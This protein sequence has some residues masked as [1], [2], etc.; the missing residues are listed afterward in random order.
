MKKLLHLTIALIPAISFAQN[1]FIN[2]G[3][4]YLQKGALLHVEGSFTNDQGTVKN[5]G[6]IEI[7]GDF[8][9]RVGSVF[10]THTDV[11]S[12]ER[13]VKFT[14][15][16]IQ[17]IK[18]DFT[19]SPFYN[20][21]IDKASATSEVVM[22]TPVSVTGSLIFG[23]NT[24]A[25]TYASNTPQTNHN[26]KG[27]LKTYSGSTEYLLSIKNGASDAIAG[28]AAMSINDNPT[29]AYILTKGNRGSSEGGVE[30]R[31]RKT[32]A[33]DF[34]IGTEENGFNGVRVNFKTIPAGGGFVRGKFNDGTDNMNGFAGVI[35]QQCTGCT[36]GNPS[37]DDRGYSNYFSASP[38][39]GSPA[40]FT[41][42]NSIT[43]HGYWSF[44]ADTNEK[45]YTYVVETFPNSFSNANASVDL[46]RTIKY[47]AAYGYN[48]S[49]EVWNGFMDSVSASTDLLQYSRNSGTCY[50][51]DGVPGG[52]YA[53]MNTHF[54]MS[55]GSSSSNSSALS[56]SGVNDGGAVFTISE[57]MP[58]PA[59]NSSKLVITTS[60]SRDITVKMVDM[61]GRE[62]S[63][64]S[65][66]LFS[67]ANTIDFNVSLLA[68]GTYNTVVAAGSQIFSKKMFVSNN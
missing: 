17:T 46:M 44:A 27:M 61:I 38:C 26:N 51:G 65:Y 64:S 40:W 6:I 29:T 22:Q 66:T 36:T 42:S 35:T 19:N 49:A 62:I 60:V 7:D 54:S 68:N 63:S 18:G 57:P 56:V 32:T 31:I 15:S 59:V 41:A 14:G 30:R 45:S 39:S 28:A 8:E 50:N 5:D 11:M 48:P 47:D 1:E 21:V 16:G 53:G 43:D 25:A 55:S 2:G 20:L 58:N 33:Y 23:T 52:I 34:P 12:K 9:N 13:A 24:V 10:G 37:P 67:G 3:D 4:L